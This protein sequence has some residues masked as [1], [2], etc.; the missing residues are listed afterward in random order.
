MSPTL[1]I[2]AVRGIV[3]LGKAGAT[4]YEQSV[5]DREIPVFHSR[6]DGR[7]LRASALAILTTVEH[8]HRLLPHG[9]LADCWQGDIETGGPVDRDAEIKLIAAAQEIWNGWMLG[10]EPEK[11]ERLL[12][13]SDA[14]AIAVLRQW[15]E[16]SG[17]PSPWVRIALAMGEVA[18]DFVAVQPDLFVES[19]GGQT[20]LVAFANNLTSLLPDP[21]NPQDW[22]DPVA[23][24][25]LTIIFR[26]GLEAVREHPD[27][28]V[29]EEH[30]RHL[31]KN[32][33]EAFRAGVV[34][35]PDNL[36]T[37]IG[38][39]DTL[40]G[41]VAKAAFTSFYE[42]QTAFLG[43]DFRAEK[44]LGALTQVLF[45]QVA[46]EGLGDF[47][48]RE[49]L[50]ETYRGLL[51]VVAEKPE[52]IL[53][54][55]DAETMELARDLLVGV[56]GVLKNAEVPY[57]GALAGKIL[58]NTITTLSHHVP[59]LIDGQAGWD[60][61]ARNSLLA[62]LD[63]V[64][65]GVAPDGS[66][67]LDHLFT[68]EQALR[69]ARIVFAEVGRTPGMILGDAGNEELRN[70]VASISRAMAAPERD[71]LSAEAWLEIAAVALEEAA[72]NPARLF[73]FEATT[74]EAE[75]GVAVIKKLLARSAEALGQGG[76]REGQV[77][78]GET[79]KEA[80][81]VSLKAAAADTTA[82][83][84]L[85]PD[86]I[87]AL[88][89]RL[90]KLITAPEPRDAGPVAG[91]QIGAREW[92]ALF[93]RLAARVVADGEMPEFSDSQLLALLQ[94]D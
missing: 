49:S 25:A 46:E 88:A 1:V 86:A 59:F 89:E 78:F 87:D 55:S 2:F 45:K 66:L 35:D 70:V 57:T 56:A 54:D 67:S 79:L 21:D 29:E 27:A 23:Q 31:T 53:G 41:P 13:P 91:F 38:L 24:K 12:V 48:T 47:F 32:V 92:L 77:L 76:R 28:L 7:N 16:D 50:V 6:L 51:T 83:A 63:G 14:A 69:F 10:V 11:G 65:T 37:W 74:P 33:A 71:L 3:R 40:L 20:L 64:K 44:A 72:R 43:K 80:I 52:L 60:V 84:D 61:V 18:L 68:D 93:R 19:K 9:D 36:F 5:V 30:L 75:L 82:G 8:E 4:A 34:G 85:L 15:A 62:F 17:P 73:G 94:E 26:A 90:N 81:I 22:Q 42:H 58:D 39:R